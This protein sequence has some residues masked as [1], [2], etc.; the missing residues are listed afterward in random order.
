MVLSFRILLDNSSPQ[1]ME[2]E[3]VCAPSVTDGLEL[4][5]SFSCLGSVTRV[6]L[7]VYHAT[8]I[9]FLPGCNVVIMLAAGS[10]GH[11]CHRIHF[12]NCLFA[13]YAL[14][15]TGYFSVPLWRMARLWWLVVLPVE[16]AKLAFGPRE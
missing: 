13:L 12:L 6:D 15:A 2:V 7:G 9:E 10:A 16:V 5:L 8:L 3:V 11:A 14:G 4:T 1:L